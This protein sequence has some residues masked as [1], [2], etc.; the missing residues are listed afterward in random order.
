MSPGGGSLKH[1]KE[2]SG[3]ANPEAVEAQ[4]RLQEAILR[5][6]PSIDPVKQHILSVPKVKDAAEAAA[7]HQ[8][9]LSVRVTPAYW[10]DAS[11]VPVDIK[12]TAGLTLARIHER[13][14]PESMPIH[15][16]SRKE[17][18]RWAR[19]GFDMSGGWPVQPQ[20]IGR[21]RH[22]R[23]TRRQI[24]MPSSPTS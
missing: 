4:R 7:H 18:A 2:T 23:S 16:V 14:K 24:R 11:G 15:A 1:S 5:Y 20:P 22:R 8:I 10:W 9:L 12:S 17:T 19:Q 6:R 3:S 21:P 13:T